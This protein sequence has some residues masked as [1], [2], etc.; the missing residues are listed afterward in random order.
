MIPDDIRRM[1][2][3][4]L[5]LPWYNRDV[6]PPSDYY[7]FMYLLAFELKPS[8]S[9]ELGVC[10]GGGC[11]HL[12]M[13]HP[14]GK[15]IGVDRAND[16]PDKLS[17]VMHHC[18]N[19]EFWPMDSVESAGCI[20]I[21]AFGRVDILFIDTIHTYDQATAEFNAYMPLLAKGAVVLL[22]DV[23]ASKMENVFD[24]L[25]PDRPHIRLDFLHPRGRVG[26]GFGVIL[27]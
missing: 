15:V 26:G 9:V 24:N 17:F 5:D 14:N 10:K 21:E 8:L 2:K 7:K 22:D 19:F 20:D 4:S 11:F 18:L 6:F 23:C 27:M 13:G 12:A 3:E 25:A 16:W 1:A